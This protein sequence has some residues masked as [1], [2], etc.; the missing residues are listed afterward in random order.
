MADI[1]AAVV[2]GCQ[3][4][5]LLDVDGG[6]DDDA[7]IEFRWTLLECVVCPVFKVVD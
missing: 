6:G 2:A 3:L 5:L 1:G 4:I 7:E